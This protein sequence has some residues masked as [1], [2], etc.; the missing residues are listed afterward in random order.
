MVSEQESWKGL[1]CLGPQPCR[2]GAILLGVR[3]ER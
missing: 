2:Q 1:M 3:L